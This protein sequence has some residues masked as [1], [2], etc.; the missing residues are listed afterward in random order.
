[1]HCESDKRIA[2]IPP[3]PFRVEGSWRILLNKAPG[4]NQAPDVRRF[5]HVEAV[6]HPHRAKEEFPTAILCFSTEDLEETKITLTASQSSSL[7]RY[8]SLNIN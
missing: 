2:A 5:V 4:F 6:A 7:S 8:F 1:M 3:R